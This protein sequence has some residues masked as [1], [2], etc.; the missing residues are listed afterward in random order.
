M[1]YND[2][3]VGGTITYIAWFLLPSAGPRP[4]AVM[5]DLA[6]NPMELTLQ[7]WDNTETA[8]FVCVR[9]SER[10]SER[11]IVFAW[12]HPGG[13]LAKAVLPNSDGRW[14]HGLAVYGEG[15]RGF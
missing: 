12:G 4:S 6:L 10:A 2:Q 3:A 1:R 15:L 13:Y 11:E 14:E 9:V 5:G 7:D 8:R